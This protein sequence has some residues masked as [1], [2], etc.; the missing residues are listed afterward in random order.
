MGNWILRGVVSVFITPWT[1]RYVTRYSMCCAI[2]QQCILKASICT[3]LRE[4]YILSDQYHSWPLL[5]YVLINLYLFNESSNM[6]R[7]NNTL[8]HVQRNTYCGLYHREKVNGLKHRTICHRVSAAIRIDRPI[9]L[10]R[11]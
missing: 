1:I 5:Q 10:P 2:A 3:P 11:R 9:R 4:Q 8:V 6:Y 7:A